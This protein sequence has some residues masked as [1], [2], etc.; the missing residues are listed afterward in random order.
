[1]K[2]SAAGK[3]DATASTRAEL[4]M[5]PIERANTPNTKERAMAPIFEPISSLSTREDID[6]NTPTRIAN[7]KASKDTLAA[8]KKAVLRLSRLIK[9]VP[10]S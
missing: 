1:M 10:P 5:S 4:I 7:A 3:I 2:V 6:R 8:F 9:T